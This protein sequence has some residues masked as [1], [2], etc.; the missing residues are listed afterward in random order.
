M[1]TITEKTVT[2]RSVLGHTDERNECECCG[3]THLKRTVVIRTVTA[4]DDTIGYYGTD[5]AAKLLACKSKRVLA[6]AERGNYAAQLEAVE[7]AFRAMP[8][9]ARAAAGIAAVR[10]TLTSA[11]G[12]RT[13]AE[14]DLALR[15]AIGELRECKRRGLI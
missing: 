9:G 12:E 13:E 4:T 1:D 7:T 11:P 6:L 10:A 3:R 15:R 2:T 14:I 8:D 5:C